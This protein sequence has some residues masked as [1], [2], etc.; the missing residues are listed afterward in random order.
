MTTV[1]PTTDPTA[2]D[3]T[4][5]PPTVTDPTTT[6]AP[7]SGPGVQVVAALLRRDDHIVLVP[8]L[9]DGYEMWFVPSGGVEQGELLSEALVREVRAET[10]LRLRSLGP[11]AYVVNT[12][13]RQF[14]SAVV[15]AFDCTDWS[16]DIAV[17]DDN[18]APGGA[19]LVPLEKAQRILSSSAT[20]RPEAE[21]LLEYLEGAGAG[22]VW[23]YRGEV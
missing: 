7:V 2:T 5:T 12:S 1:D 23:S 3:P 18:A 6:L 8:A 22:R 11:L 15:L 16:G 10:G 20:C 21:P 4:V 13:T 14:P 17:H 9:R 19:V